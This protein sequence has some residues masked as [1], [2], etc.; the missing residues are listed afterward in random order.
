[1]GHARGGQG[2]DRLQLRVSVLFVTWQAM[3]ISWVWIVGM[4]DM[5]FNRR[6][7]RRL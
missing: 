7:V 5:D 6:G 4:E 3:G 1:M 2:T